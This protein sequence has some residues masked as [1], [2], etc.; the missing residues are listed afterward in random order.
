M[1]ALL[2]ALFITPLAG[3]LADRF[4]RRKLL[5]F[6]YALNMAHNLLLSLLV[7]SGNGNEYHIL[8]LAILN[9]SF[10]AIEMPTNQALL[11]NLVPRER[12][13]NA[14]ALAQLVQQ[15][16][17]MLGPLMILPIISFI[18]YEPAFFMSVALYA[19]GWSQ[20]MRIRT[21]SRGVVE[22]RQGVLFN[23]AAGIRHIYRQPL[24]LSL[25]LL[26]VV[27]CALTMAFES[28]FPFFSRTA[29]GMET[30][31]GL[32]Q[33]PTFLMIAVGGGSIIGNLALAKVH[34]QRI[35]G[36]LLLVLGFFSGATPIILGFTF[37]VPTAMIAAAFMG[38]STA[39][40]MTLSHGM[41]QSITPDAIRG[42]VLSASTWHVQGAMAGFNAVNGIMMD[43]AWMTA[44][45]LLTATG[46]IFMSI[47]V[48]SF[49][50]VPL[51]GI[52]SRGIPSEAYAH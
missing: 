13:L 44:P 50:A 32:F 35:R 4:D 46:L 2:P 37:N 51:R 31:K 42:R 21:V 18:G 19:L 27:H 7:L 11:P 9:G 26:T 1:S 39:S 17:R 29:L 6:T 30:E 14:V 25:I 52:Y 34:S 10:R 23:L 28:V 3:F 48:S 47:M 22:T 5:A 41:V 40:F 45:L 20:V 43:L 38:A 33:G 24:L 12:L 8:G 36:R 15:G 16:S 49:L